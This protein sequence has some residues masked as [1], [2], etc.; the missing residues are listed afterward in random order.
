MLR[1]QDISQENEGLTKNSA[2][3]ISC[4]NTFCAVAEQRTAAKQSAAASPKQP[5]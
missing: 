2:K 5:L 4:T 3:V 1:E